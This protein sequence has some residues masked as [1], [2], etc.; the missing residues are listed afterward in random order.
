M[1]LALLVSAKPDAATAQ[2]P[3]EPGIVKMPSEEWPLDPGFAEVA[4]KYDRLLRAQSLSADELAKLIAR[5]DDDKARL[6]GVRVRISSHQNLAQRGTESALLGVCYA[7]MWRPGKARWE[8]ANPGQNGAKYSV[9][10][11][12]GSSLIW[13]NPPEQD[14]D[15]IY[16]SS[17]GSCVAY[18]VPNGA[19]ATFHSAESW[20]VCYNVFACQVLGKCPKWVNPCDNNS[21][22]GSWPDYPLQ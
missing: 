15:G 4:A 13:A 2:G 17:W 12:T 22:E 10:P 6:L 3:S 14:I 16:R 7:P 9:L 19:T 21:P 18:K 11:E 8:F 1:L 20:E 5:D